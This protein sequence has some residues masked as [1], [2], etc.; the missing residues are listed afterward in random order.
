MKAIKTEHSNHN[1]GPPKGQEDVITDLPCEIEDD[2]PGYARG[3]VIW[4]VWEPSE[5][6]RRAIANGQNIKL[7]VGWIGG[8]PPVSV[9]VTAETKVEG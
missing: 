5:G 9:G 7:G 4:S 2:V 1:F 3:R 8:F 6:E